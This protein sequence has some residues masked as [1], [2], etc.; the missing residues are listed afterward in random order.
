MIVCGLPKVMCIYLRMDIQ[1]TPEDTAAVSPACTT[2]FRWL[3]AFINL[4][5]NTCSEPALRS[6]SEVSWMIPQPAA[7]LGVDVNSLSSSGLFFF[8]RFFGI[9]LKIGSIALYIS[10]VDRSQKSTNHNRHGSFFVRPKHLKN[11]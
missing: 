2:Y 9:A 10:R 5:W 11:D 6:L 7:P 4:T 8:G 1:Q 3:P